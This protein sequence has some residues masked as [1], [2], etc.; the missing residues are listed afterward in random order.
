MQQITFYTTKKPGGYSGN[1]LPSIINTLEQKRF[2]LK[3][4]ALMLGD[5]NPLNAQWN[6]GKKFKRPHTAQSF[7]F[8]ST[9]HQDWYISNAYAFKKIYSRNQWS[10]HVHIVPQFRNKTK[11]RKEINGLKWIN[12]NS[13]FTH[14]SLHSF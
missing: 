11:K 9:F 7:F 14:F 6:E 1:Y 5:G 8:I 4:A 2:V 12:S 3:M 10:H 13:D